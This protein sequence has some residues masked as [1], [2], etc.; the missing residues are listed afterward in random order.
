[1]K[2]LL[3]ENLPRKLVA[4]LRAEGHEVE[5]VITLRMQGLDNGRLYRFARQNFEVCF[6][7]DFGFA[8]NVRQ[9][10]TPENFKLLRVTLAQRPQDEFIQNFLAAFRAMEVRECAH[11]PEVQFQDFR[12]LV[13][14]ARVFA[15]RVHSC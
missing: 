3:D 13:A 2:I 8:N 6:T 10:P 14:S 7:R 12:A 1:V 4:A 9:G 5:S 11:V 15:G